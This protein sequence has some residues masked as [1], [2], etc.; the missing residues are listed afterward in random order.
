VKE[1]FGKTKAVIV[2]DIPGKN[3][4]GKNFRQGQGQKKGIEKK[5]HGKRS[6][7][8]IDGTTCQGE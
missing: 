2:E 1:N 8:N 5:R 7:L 3:L 4:G 6:F